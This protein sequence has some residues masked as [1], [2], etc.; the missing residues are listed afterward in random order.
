M[1]I[2]VIDLPEGSAAGT[3]LITLIADGMPLDDVIE[4]AKPILDFID[5]HTP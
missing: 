4:A 5:F 1:R 3:L 2:Y